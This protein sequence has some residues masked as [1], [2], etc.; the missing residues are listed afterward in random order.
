MNKKGSQRETT[1]KHIY[2]AVWYPYVADDN[3]S[4]CSDLMYVPCWMSFTLISE[5]EVHKHKT[6]QNKI[7]KINKTHNKKEKVQ[8]T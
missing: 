4:A 1:L 5:L 6:N 7:N 2:K 3:T 8:K